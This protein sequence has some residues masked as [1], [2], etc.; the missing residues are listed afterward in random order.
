MVWVT[1]ALERELPDLGPVQVTNGQRRLTLDTSDRELRR[2]FAEEYAREKARI[3][4]FVAGSGGIGLELPCEEDPVD[5]L[6]QVFGPR[7]SGTARF[8]AAQWGVKR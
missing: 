7:H 1:D 6:R 5:I 8:G 4:A 2:R 3:A